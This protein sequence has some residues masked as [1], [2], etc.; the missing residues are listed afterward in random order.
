MYSPICKGG[1]LHDVAEDIHWGR[2]QEVSWN[3][4][5]RTYPN[6][7]GNE[8]AEKLLAFILGIVSHQV[9]VAMFMYGCT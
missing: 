7:I 6:P 3:Y 5:R 1:S 4:F 8:H 9:N 2:F